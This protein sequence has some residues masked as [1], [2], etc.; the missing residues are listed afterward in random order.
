[1]RSIPTRILA[2][3]AVL[4]LLSSGCG[5]DGGPSGD[6]NHGADTLDTATTSAIN[7]KVLRVKG[8]IFNVPSPVETALLIKKAG[9]T[10]R[11]DHTLALEAV[12]KMT[13]RMQQSLALG[14]YGADMAY[15]TIHRDGAR[16]LSTLQAIEKLGSALEVSNA[17]DPSLIDRYRDN[18]NNEDSLLRISGDAFRAADLYLKGNERDDVSA[19]VLAGGWIESMHLI[20]SEGSTLSDQLATRIGEQKRTIRDL[21]ALLE[22]SDRNT[23]AGELIDGLKEAGNVLSMVNTAYQFSEPT[24]DVA[25]KIT[26]IT[27]RSSV[28][29]TAEQVKALSERIAKLR[30]LTIA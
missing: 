3:C 30:N 28:T 13:G 15:V 18:L 8:R 11:K 7:T 9:A 1:M 19:L 2:A 27:S 10:Y 16:A 6:T 12:E 24:T 5:G 29:I 25:N 22:A 21:V 4:G 14:M 20:L 17:F 23:I 26:T